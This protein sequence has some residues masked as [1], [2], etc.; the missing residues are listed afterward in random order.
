MFCPRCGQQQATDSMR[1]CSRCG[2]A[3]EGVMHLLAHGGMLPVQQPPGEKV[4]SARAKG[5]MQGAML[6]LL[7]ALIVPIF[8]V[9]SAFAPGRLEN[10]FAFFAAMSAIISFVGGPL[11]LLFAAIFEEGAPKRYQF[12]TQ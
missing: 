10:V 7:G 12:S 9:M 1:F 2:F 11:R 6:M 5:V 3:M 4:R 8:G